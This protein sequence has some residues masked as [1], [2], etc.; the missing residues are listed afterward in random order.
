MA[1]KRWEGR[2][3]WYEKYCDYPSKKRVKRIKR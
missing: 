2:W 3:D 1:Y